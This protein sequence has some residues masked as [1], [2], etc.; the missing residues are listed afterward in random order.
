MDF[1]T[2]AE[3][4]KRA[5]PKAILRDAKK[6]PASVYLLTGEQDQCESLARELI[7]VLVPEKKRS[8]H[9]EVYEGRNT[10][11]STVLDSCRTLGL[12]GGG[13]VV[14][15][16]EPAFLSSTEK[17]PEITDAM[18]SA[19]AAERRKQAAEKLLLLAALAGWSQQDLDSADFAKLPKTKAKSL[20]GRDMAGD[21]AAIVTAIQSYAAEAGLSV[22]SQQDDGAM[23]ESFLSSEAGGD[24]VLVLTASAADRR[25]RIFK[26]IQK[27]GVVAELKVD[28]ERSGAMTREAVEQLIDDTLDR[29]GK[30]LG[31]R[32][33]Q[34]VVKRAGP[35][36]TQLKH[37]LEKLCL[38]AGDDESISDDD[39][40]TLMRDL[41]ESWI[42]DFTSALAQRNVT[43]S[44]ALLRGLF[45]QGEPPLRLLA[46]MTR[47]IRILLAAREILSTT[48][49]R[50]WNDRTT[51]NRFRDQLLPQIPDEQKQSI[52]GM[53]PYVLYLALQNASRTSMAK[54]RRALIELHELDIAFKSS[55]TDPQIRLEAFVIDLAGR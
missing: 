9:L 3:S 49:A 34:I 38:Y 32:G 21:D 12:F 11:L 17:R 13:K 8:V 28:R 40:A 30:R 18:M 46:M 39:T 47:E 45:A 7:E 53:H 31:A 24:S 44:I 37:E 43:Q 25:K 16:R 23:L 54:L 51:F 1:R 33:R 35:D 2:V 55:R 20:L 5:N 41:G 6:K 52:G 19:W 14:W 36:P 26:Q 48:L 15:L 27:A 4:A 29:H 22:A 50:S 42:F 10:P